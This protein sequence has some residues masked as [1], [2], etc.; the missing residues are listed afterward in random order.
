MAAD[1]A[2]T[3]ARQASAARVSAAP[4]PKAHTHRTSPQLPQAPSPSAVTWGGGRRKSLLCTCRLGAERA[5]AWSGCALA[6]R[7]ARRGWLRRCAQGRARELAND[8]MR[9][10]A[11]AAD[12]EEKVSLLTW[13]QQTDSARPHAVGAAGGRDETHQGALRTARS[14]CLGRRRSDGGTVGRSRGRGGD[15]V[16]VVRVRVRAGQARQVAGQQQRAGGGAGG[17]RGGRG[18]GQA[19]AGAGRGAKA[20]R[21]RGSEAERGGGEEAGA[22]Q[23][24]RRGGRGAGQAGAGAGR[25]GKGRQE[26]RERSR[27]RRRRGGRCGTERTPRWPRGRT[28]CGRCGEGGKGREESRARQS[29]RALPTRRQSARREV[30]HRHSRCRGVAVCPPGGVGLVCVRLQAEEVLVAARKAAADQEAQVR[31]TRRVT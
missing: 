1:A 31:C 21:R 28:S 3:A 25:G 16:C 20:G 19:A 29:S 7:A 14:C 5:A 2:A 12:L 30:P 9:L 15:A 8:R 6:E 26:E 11:D 4:V 18:A 27:E 17:R 10:E 24:G 23:R 22:G 13:Q